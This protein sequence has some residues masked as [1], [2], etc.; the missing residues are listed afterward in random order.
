MNMFPEVEGKESHTGFQ[1]TKR[2]K[3]V[4]KG[5]IFVLNLSLSAFHS[6][7]VANAVET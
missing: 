3:A 7:E 5:R 4:T 2:S 6:R 1:E